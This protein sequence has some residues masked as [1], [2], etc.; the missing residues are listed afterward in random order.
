[1]ETFMAIYGYDWFQPP[2]QPHVTIQNHTNAKDYKAIAQNPFKRNLPPEDLERLANDPV[3]RA[4]WEELVVH[5]M[6][7]P[8]RQLAAT[9]PTTVRPCC[10]L[11]A[12]AMYYCR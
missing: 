5:T 9:I 11:L 10:Q 12:M 2:T 4:H 8:L 1:M 7:P 6:L 3:K